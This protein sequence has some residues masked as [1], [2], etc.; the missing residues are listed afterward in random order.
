M[1]EFRGTAVITVLALVGAILFIAL[2]L[3]AYA[4][5][6]AGGG[7]GPRAQRALTDPPASR[8]KDQLSPVAGILVVQKAFSRPKPF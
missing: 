7:V 8:L 1:S 2:A 4:L 6:L 5:C 3:I